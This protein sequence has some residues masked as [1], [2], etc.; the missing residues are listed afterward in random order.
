[1]SPSSFLFQHILEQVHIAP[2][3]PL[4]GKHLLHFGPVVFFYFSSQLWAFAQL[5]D[6]F[7]KGVHIPQGAEIAL[8]NM[9]DEF[10]YTSRQAQNVNIIFTY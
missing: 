10:L 7:G 4:Q 8:L 9:V 1:M 5:V 2:H 3:H 6:P